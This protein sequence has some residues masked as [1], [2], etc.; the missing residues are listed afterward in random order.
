M[1]RCSWGLMANSWGFDGSQYYPPH[2]SAWSKLQL[3]YVTPTDITTSGVYYASAVEDNPQV[4]PL[5]PY[6][7]ICL[8]LVVAF[9]ILV[10]LVMPHMQISILPICAFVTQ[11][12]R[13]RTGFPTN[14]YLLIENRQNLAFDA[15]IPSGGSGLLIFHIDDSAGYNTQSVP[16]ATNWPAH[17]RV[18]VAQVQTQCVFAIGMM[19]S[20]L[21][22]SHAL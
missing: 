8:S 5:S 1:Q 10:H 9:V 19:P 12:F 21:A 6:A 3:G 18:A 14:E 22:F 13:I 7:A 4:W 17:Y 11:V 15:A 16:G 20:W 2:L